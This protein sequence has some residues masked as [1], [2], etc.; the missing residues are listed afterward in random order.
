MSVKD[1]LDRA[2]AF[3][4]VAESGD[5]RQAAYERAALEIEAAM[6]ADPSLS[7][8]KIGKRIGK[9]EVY[10]NRLLKAL[11]RT[12]RTGEPFKVDWQS[13]TNRR[14]DLLPAAIK[15]ASA[16]E[17][18]D[19]A[20][21]LL[22][23]PA[24]AP[25]VLATSTPASSNM[26]TAVAQGNAEQ[27]GAGK[28]RAKQRREDGAVPLPAHLAAMVRK[29]DE[30]ALALAGIA[31]DELAELPEGRGVELVDDA[32]ERLVVQAERWRAALGRDALDGGLLRVVEGKKG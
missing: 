25:A 32:L 13:G 15:K 24:V 16:Q 30:W 29:I 28:E 19:L 8:A 6:E 12:R 22:E 2:A 10:V 4:A 21:G 3:I 26:K 1:H 9:G 14:D 31:D 7:Q 11:L 5:S 18:V 20:T 23:V 17:K 27:R